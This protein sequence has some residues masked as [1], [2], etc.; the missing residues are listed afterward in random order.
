MYMRIPWLRTSRSRE[1]RP[2]NLRSSLKPMR[3]GLAKCDSA[4][5]EYS[6]LMR[7]SVVGRPK[8][9]DPTGQVAHQRGA[10]NVR[11]PRRRA[12]STKIIGAL[13][14]LILAGA[15]AQASPGLGPVAPTTPTI[16]ESTGSSSSTSPSSS[17]SSSSSSPSTASP[18]SPST[19]SVAARTSPTSTPAPAPVPTA[20][21][22]EPIRC[23]SPVLLDKRDTTWLVSNLLMVGIPIRSGVRARE[24]VRTQNIAGILVRGTPRAADA[25]LLK[26]IGAARS[27]VPTIVAVDEEGGRVQHLATAIGRLPSA[28]L[29]AETKTPQQVRALI[30]THAIAMKKLGFTFVFGPVLDLQFGPDKGG[31][32]GIGDRAFSP[33]PNIVTSYGAAFVQGMLDAGIYPVVKHFPGGGRADG[34]PHNKGTVSPSIDEIRLL[35]LVP[36]ASLI[37]TFPVGVMV[38]HQQV[39]GLD[40]VPASLS[41]KAVNGVLRKELGFTGLTI[42]DSLSMW[43]VAFNFNRVQAATLALKAGNDILLFDDEPNVADI[44][45]GL[46]KAVDADP[47]LRVRAVNAATNVLR[48]KG[49]PLCAGAPATLPSSTTSTTVG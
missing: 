1:C 7:L 26:S 30:R 16:P 44:I 21:P 10:E 19:S 35:D 18:S 49:L 38:G 20:P 3:A 46:T 15:Q 47:K 27:D 14:T 22:P 25:A 40:A 28:K 36:F 5:T 9:T 11:R 39:P 32:N 48:A 33:D 31:A 8:A 4:G 34:D 45:S 13:I 42:T 37:R 6:D 23:V 43:S 24:L 29:M 41:P 17:P 2:L 12:T